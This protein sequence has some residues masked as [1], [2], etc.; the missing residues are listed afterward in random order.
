M[1]VEACLEDWIAGLQHLVFGSASGMA[2]DRVL[3]H[4]TPAH[5]HNLA[6]MASNAE[7]WCQQ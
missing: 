7:Y 1:Q 6:W 2:E 4:M 5:D 3:H